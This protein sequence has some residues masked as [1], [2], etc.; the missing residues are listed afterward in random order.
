[1]NVYK[2]MVPK[3]LRSKAHGAIRE[4][5]TMGKGDRGGQRALVYVRSYLHLAPETAFPSPEHK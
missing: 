1:M 4:N 3:D 5:E 2:R